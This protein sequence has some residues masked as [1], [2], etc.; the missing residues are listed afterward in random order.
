M[1][2]EPIQK[3]REFIIHGEVKHISRSDVDKSG[4]NPKYKISINLAPTKIEG[5]EIYLQ[6]D[7]FIKFQANEKEIL[8]QI[9]RL[10]IVGDNLVIESSAI[11]E[12]QRRI[13]PIKKIKFKDTD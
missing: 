7:S 9:D 12:Y 4:R 13:L 5:C 8:E 3:K 1:E 2:S 10:P 11:I 6:F